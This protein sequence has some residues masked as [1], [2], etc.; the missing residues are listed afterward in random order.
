M[1]S[2]DVTLHRP[3]NI[4]PPLRVSHPDTSRYE[5]VWICVSGNSTI[6]SDE[7]IHGVC[8]EN[9]LLTCEMVTAKFTKQLGCLCS[10]QQNRL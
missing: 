2:F 9:L 4:A 7:D 3:L 1:P 6:Y 8:D 10:A 5:F